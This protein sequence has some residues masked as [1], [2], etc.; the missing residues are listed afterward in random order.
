MTAPFG[1]GFFRT[2]DGTSDDDDA[3]DA[4]DA[5]L[6]LLAGAL[7]ASI[8]ELQAP[9]ELQF[10]PG[11]DNTE[12]FLQGQQAGQG[13]ILDSVYSSIWQGLQT[14][15]KAF[16]LSN[17]TM[18]QF[19]S[20]NWDNGGAQY[21][22]RA[23]NT[24]ASGPSD[25]GAGD[26]MAKDFFMGSIEGYNLLVSSVWDWFN[27][28]SPVDLGQYGKPSGPGGSGSGRR[29]LS[30]QDIR[31]QFDLDQLSEAADS[32][33]R[34]MLLEDTA[35][36][37][38]MA[39]AY[40]D[41]MVAGKGEVKID[42]T[43]FIRQRA[44]KTDRFAAIYQNKPS[45]LSPEQYMAPYFAAAQQVARPDTADDIAIG[46]AQFGSDANTFGARLRRTD[47]ATSSSNFINELQGRLSGLS[48]VFRG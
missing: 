13:Q 39:R 43:E 32:I 31:N 42:F 6:Q 29:G 25:G 9:P 23:L 27:R 47:E 8:G 26:A 33:W 48:G 2:H 11:G 46:G 34:G 35:D 28:K 30:E 3:P 24:R 19:F 5:T 44:M 7:A 20:F 22:D 45:S 15:G 37:R 1:G 18:F 41:A 40:V 38:S 17:D 21:V 4:P 16:G 36:S 10:I 12:F 14:Y